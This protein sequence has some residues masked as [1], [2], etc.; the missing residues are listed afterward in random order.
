MDGL[1]ENSKEM[2]AKLQA[3]LERGKV[4]WE[5][6]T[7]MKGVRQEKWQEYLLSKFCC[8]D[9]LYNW[10]GRLSSY[11][12]GKMIV[13]NLQAPQYFIS[14]KGRHDKGDMKISFDQ[15]SIIPPSWRSVP[16]PALPDFA[17]VGPAAEAQQH[18]QLVDTL[19]QAIDLCSHFRFVHSVCGCQ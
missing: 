14:F 5:T 17:G 16:L 13:D 9:D 12:E 3:C 10:I 19:R 8:G 4:L 15:S 11:A 18:Q 6:F 1:P 2:L 7:T